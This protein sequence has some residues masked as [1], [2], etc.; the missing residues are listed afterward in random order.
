[1]PE[2]KRNFAAPCGLYCGACRIYR[3]NKRGDSGFLSNMKEQFTK[4]FAA[5]R[6]GERAPGVPTPLPEAEISRIRKEIEADKVDLYCEGCLSK[7]VAFPCRHCGFRSCARQKGVIN[8]SS[9]PDVPCSLLIDFK[10]DGILHHGEILNNIARQKEVGI[11]AWLAEQEERWKCDQ[12]GAFLGWYD[13]R[14]PDCGSG[15]IRTF[16]SLPISGK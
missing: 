13:P 15:Q 6:E 10:N 11:D 8:C 2:K 3:A 9:C 12:C 4:G 5:L 16:G 14:C 1:M 7:T